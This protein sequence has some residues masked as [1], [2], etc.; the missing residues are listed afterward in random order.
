MI[1]TY[2]LIFWMHPQYLS[3]NEIIVMVKNITSQIDN[4]LYDGN[5]KLFEQAYKKSACKE[6]DITFEYLNKFFNKKSNRTNYELGIPY[7]FSFFS[8][9]NEEESMKISFSLGGNGDNLKNSIIVYLPQN[10]F[11]EN[12]KF[13]RVCNLFKAIVCI[14]SPYFAF[15]PNSLNNPFTSYWKDKPTYIHTLNY[16]KNNLAQTIGVDKLEKLQ[17][18]E[19]DDG[20]WY[21]KLLDEPLDVNNTSHLEKQ[22]QISDFLGL[23]D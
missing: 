4:I 2:T 13:Q 14:S 1:Q 22:K 20:G 16:F 7:S 21:L 8:S 18:T 9:F 23:T 3:D 15:M 5:L 11:E 17:N 6:V 10:I 12:D 19:E